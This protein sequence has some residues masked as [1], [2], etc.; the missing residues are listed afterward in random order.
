MRHTMPIMA[1]AT[2]LMTA[3]AATP[4]ASAQALCT[5]YEDENTISPPGVDAV[6]YVRT[7]S[8][9]VY[10][11]DLSPPSI[12]PPTVCTGWVQI[13][14]ETNQDPG[15]QEDK[16]MTTGHDPDWCIY[17]VGNQCDNVNNRP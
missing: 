5:Q 17:G 7:A 13:W 1:A 9:G 8:P 10:G 12:D 2:L 11:G 16:D 3:I 15:L 6:Y 14:M 4:T